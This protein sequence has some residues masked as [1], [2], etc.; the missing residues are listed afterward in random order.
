MKVSS[1]SL[2]IFIALVVCGFDLPGGDGAPIGSISTSKVA[3]IPD[4]M[5]NI[6]VIDRDN[7]GV[8]QRTV[9]LDSFPVFTG[10]PLHISGS[11]IEGGIV[12]NMDSDADLEI[13]YNIGYTVQA[14][15]PDGTPVPGWPKTVA[16]YP[17]E[18]AP[19]YGDI[20]GDGQ[21][22]IVVTNHGLTSG[23]FIYAFRMNG[24]I[25]PGF[26]INHGYSSR[27][28]VLADLNGDGAMEIIVNKRLSS[29]GEVWVYKGNGTVYPGWPKP[30][31]HVPASSAAVGDLTGDGVPEIVAESYTALYA[32]KANGDT[33][34]GFPF[35][36][37]NSAT[38]SYS[39]PVL[40]DID[41]DG[42]KD[43]VF[44]THVL[45]GG[46]YVFALKKDGTQLP[47]WPQ[48]TSQWIYGPPA[49]AYIDADTVLDIAI[50]DQVLSGTPADYLYA[51]NANG[52]PLQGFPVGP[53]NAINNQ[54]AIGDVNN[55][56]MMELIVDD[57]TSA[58]V[59][60]GFNHN[61]AP[62]AGWPITATGTTFFNMP[63]LADV[64]HD[65]TLDIVG[66][67]R[68][69]T[70]TTF[71]NVYLWNTG[72]PYHQNGIAVPVWQYNVRHDG[73]F[74]ERTVLGVMERNRDV[75]T[76]VRLLQNYPNP[77]NP[78]TIIQYTIPPGRRSVV[79][80]RVYDLLG[81]EVATLVNEAQPPG[82]HEATWDA[83]GFASGIY[84]Y[85]LEADGFTSTRK[86]MLL[87]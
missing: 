81:R 80:L 9:N 7:N 4:V 62:L 52:S 11:S 83:S 16:S 28:P 40:A 27:T 23:G 73:V 38:N 41:H 68:E 77:F 86:L 67:A 72:I 34:P 44:G 5:N 17:L 74:D 33:L 2:L 3:V 36:M 26:P 48:A 51:W 49:V 8:H 42:Y 45:T 24:D 32:W 30:I 66:A 82:T 59:Y 19:A 47:G 18:G 35:Y 60:L 56:G 65:D 63:C 71:T 1:Y 29:A 39:S 87:R 53:L 10:F 78:A 21:P 75:A 14:W 25:V 54:V 46:G 76:D 61:G 37:P 57:N 22:E 84:F 20:D 69:G 58:G 55:D 43:I 79:S 31:G 85:R 6:N 13:V 15:N 50:G 70:T 64:N 12:C